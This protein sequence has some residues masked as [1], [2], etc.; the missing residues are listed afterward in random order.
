MWLISCF[1]YSSNMPSLPK[2]SDL[3]DMASTKAFINDAVVNG[4]SMIDS[5]SKKAANAYKTVSDMVPSDVEATI[6]VVAVQ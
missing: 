6:K 5:A 4:Q 2:L 3:P 1:V